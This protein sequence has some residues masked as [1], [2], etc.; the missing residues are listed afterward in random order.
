MPEFDIIVAGEYLIDLI[1]EEFT[2]DLSAAETYRRRPGGSPANMG[3][4]MARLGHSVALVASIGADPTGKYL[5]DYI[6]QYQVD[7]S[8]LV[9][10]PVP[11]TL[12]FVTRSQEVS[13]FMLYR[14]A[15]YQISD[16]QFWTVN[17][18]SA[19][20]FHTTCFGLSM[21]PARSAILA[22]A[23]KAQ[24]S[25]RQLSIDLN[26]ASKVWPNLEEAKLII[27]AYV[28]RGALVKVSSVD[29]G[30]LYDTNAEDNPNAVLDHFLEMGANE[31]CLTLGGDGC[32]VANAEERHFLPTRPVEVK[33]TTGAGDAFWSGYLS[34]WIAGNTLLDRAKAGRRMAELKLVHFGPLGKNVD[35]DEVL[36]G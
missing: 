34:A 36:S 21:E 6:D 29:W 33:D 16:E 15:D 19:L 3:M 26:Y 14:S 13:D 35:R 30:R 12:V 22:A 11:T 27:K 9:R 23:A 10:V 20:I 5:L 32:W 7:T 24:A 17:P 31:V 1:S 8:G 4:N 18:S 25:Q 28:S 2:E